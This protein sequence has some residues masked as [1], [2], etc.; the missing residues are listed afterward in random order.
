M[1]TTQMSPVSVGAG[2]L[3][4]AGCDLVQAV[5]ASLSPQDRAT[6]EGLEAAGA[7]LGVTVQW[8]QNHVAVR[9]G[10]PPSD[11]EPPIC[12]LALN[13]PRDPAG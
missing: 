9:V 10:F 1:N 13:W 6:M 7:E 5:R 2:D 12:I 4:T 11:G 3:I 8:H